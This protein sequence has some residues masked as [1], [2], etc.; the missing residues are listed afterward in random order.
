MDFYIW[1]ELSMKQLTFDE[2]FKP[3]GNVSPCPYTK[4]CSTFGVG[5]KGESWWCKQ[6]GI[7]Y[8][9][10]KTPICFEDYIGNCEYCM[11]G[12]NPITCQWSDQNPDKRKTYSECHN[13]SFWKPDSWKIPKL[14]GSCKYS[15]SFHYQGED[16]QNPIEEPNIFCTRT[17]GSVNR[18]KPYKQFEEEGFGVNTWDRQHEWDSCDAWEQDSW[19]ADCVAKSKENL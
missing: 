12:I 13:G 16:F 9:K 4:D 3:N 6:K 15:N 10:K 14:C 17:D 8:E 1:K 7:K 5:C 11:W 19:K 2:L 18:I